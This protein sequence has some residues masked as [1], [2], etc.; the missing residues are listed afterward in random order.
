MATSGP[1]FSVPGK[2]MLAG[3]YAVLSGQPC[4]A[5][6]LSPRLRVTVTPTKSRA[7]I[8]RSPVVSSRPYVVRPVDLAANAGQQDPPEWRFALATLRHFAAH[9]R[10]AGA[11][12]DI[13]SEFPPSLGLGS[14]SGVTLA[15]AAGL[16]AALEATQI[17]EIGSD[18]VPD[19]TALLRFARAVI[20]KV[21]GAGSGFD[22]AAQL[23]GGIIRYQLPDETAVEPTDGEAEEID[24]DAAPT[25]PD[26][27]ITPIYAPDLPLLVGYQGHKANTQAALNAYDDAWGDRVT[28]RDKIAAQ[29]GVSVE[30]AQ[31]ALM[32]GDWAAAGKAF[33]EDQR[34]L[35][36]LK[37]VP[38]DV[39]KALKKA[40]AELPFGAKIS[41][42]GGGDCVVALVADADEAAARFPGYGWEPMPTLRPQA[43]G[44]QLDLA[45]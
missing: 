15:L 38:A 6:A 29:I 12:I 10:L 34:L 42:A 25:T 14:S 1:T 35:E 17:A 39:A 27:I 37:V 13:T 31:K 19:R 20:T 32:K 30:Q 44:L 22:A 3:E 26:P 24:E 5:T 16:I 40:N 11:R 45:G 43:P 2:L 28:E 33:Q 7:L 4:L 8:F 23:Y 41:G 21:Q 9:A 18:G 36:L